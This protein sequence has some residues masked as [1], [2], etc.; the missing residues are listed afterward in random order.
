MAT[1]DIPGQSRQDQRVSLTLLNLGY[2]VWCANTTRQRPRRVK[3]GC[4][5]RGQ[6]SIYFGMQHSEQ[7][8]VIILNGTL[9]SLCTLCYPC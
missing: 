8:S 3:R 2:A 7:C 5:I 1:W 9:G 6:Y 4:R